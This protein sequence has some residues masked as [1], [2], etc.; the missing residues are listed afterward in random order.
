MNLVHAC[1]VEGQRP[2]D[3]PRINL[4]IDILSVYFSNSN[5]W[6]NDLNSK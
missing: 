1:T 4:G 5:G 3:L 2:N 6:L